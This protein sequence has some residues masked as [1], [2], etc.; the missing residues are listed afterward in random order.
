[1]TKCRAPGT[2]VSGSEPAPLRRQHAV[3]PTDTAGGSGHTGRCSSVRGGRTGRS[4]S[5]EGRVASFNGAVASFDFR[6]LGSLDAGF[7]SIFRLN[8]PAERQWGS[9]LTVMS[10]PDRASF[11]SR[12]TQCR[13]RCRN[14]VR[15][16]SG[17]LSM[18]SVFFTK[19]ACAESDAGIKARL[20]TASL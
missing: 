7:A 13:D 3:H 16:L 10:D 6:V 14:S 12:R 4:S 20:R 18:T 5:L 1:M 15:W 19:S 11:P 9:P 2:E 8:V 17:N